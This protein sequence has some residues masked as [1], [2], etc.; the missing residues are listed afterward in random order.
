MKSKPEYWY[1]QSAVIPFR[2]VGDEIEILLI[3][4]RK[5]KKWIIPKGIIEDNLS[6]RESAIK[7]AYEEAGI[8]GNL[9]KGRIGKYKYKK[10]GGKCK[11]KVYALQVQTI[12]DSW[13]ED[14]RDRIWIKSNSI[15]RYSND[16]NFR[17]LVN[18]LIL[19]IKTI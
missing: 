8:K 12:F 2:K 19:T 18:K 1:N 3:R 11:V 13:E 6:S 5:N 16:Q 9:I 14:Y 17:L 4:N 7:E 10:W 15:D